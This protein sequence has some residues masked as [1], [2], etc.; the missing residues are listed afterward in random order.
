MK[1]L[2]I[3]SHVLGRD[4]NFFMSPDGGQIYLKDVDRYGVEP[5]PILWHESEEPVKA[6][7]KSFNKVCHDWY[8]KQL[9]IERSS[10]QPGL[11]PGPRHMHAR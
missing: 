5:R 1:T 4:F 10:G 2:R 11:T 9:E 8:E 6:T 3:K 7:P